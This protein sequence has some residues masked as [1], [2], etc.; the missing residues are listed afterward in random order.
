MFRAPCTQMLKLQE[1]HPQHRPLR[2]EEIVL[3]PT[4]FRPYL[5]GHG[6]LA[7]RLIMGIVGVIIWL[8]VVM[9]LLTKSP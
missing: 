3:N 5:E 2:P 7:G 1:P 4:L 9:N 6:D 8:M